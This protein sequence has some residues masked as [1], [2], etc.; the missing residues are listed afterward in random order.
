MAEEVYTERTN[1]VAVFREIDRRPKIE[2]IVVNN[3][4][5]WSAILAVGIVAIIAIAV[6]ASLY[7]RRVKP[8]YKCPEA[9]TT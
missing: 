3:D 7:T 1:D 2:P 8:R 5:S 4:I 6:I 9:N